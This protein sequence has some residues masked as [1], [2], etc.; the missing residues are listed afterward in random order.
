MLNLGRRNIHDATLSP[1]KLPYPRGE[2]DSL[3]T[4]SHYHNH[5]HYHSHSS[6]DKKSSRSISYQPEQVPAYQ[7]KSN[8]DVVEATFV[9]PN[10]KGDFNNKNYFDPIHQLGIN[11]LNFSSPFLTSN[12]FSTTVPK[13]SISL[14]SYTN[15]T[16][17]S[18]RNIDGFITGTIL[19][20]EARKGEETETTDDE[21]NS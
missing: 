18:G 19:S 1:G 13:R 20:K 9:F 21:E 11:N 14:D 3:L 16:N 4:H 8:P 12:V 15:K 10:K 6:D 17:R 2:D 5:Q 7:V